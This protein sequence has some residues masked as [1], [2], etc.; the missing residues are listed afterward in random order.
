[1]ETTTLAPKMSKLAGC[2]QL[3][4][5]IVVVLL[6][7]PIIATLA[8]IALYGVNVPF[9]DDWLFIEFMQKYMTQGITLQDLFKQHNEHRI[10]FP[11]LVMLGLAL[12]TRYNSVAQMY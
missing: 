1:M 9:L 6:L 12:P 8:Y 7:C 2:I 10:F 5:A 4:R 3:P 11:R